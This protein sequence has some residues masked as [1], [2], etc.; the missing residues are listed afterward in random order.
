MNNVSFRF[1]SLRQVEHAI[2]LAYESGINA[3]K[4]G[5][6]VYFA[7]KYVSVESIIQASLS[8]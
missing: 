6:R 5:Y 1:C 3:Y 4:I 7:A 2:N 8:V